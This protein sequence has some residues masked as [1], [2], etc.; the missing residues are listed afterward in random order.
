[1]RSVEASSEQG[2]DVRE[3]PVKVVVVVSIVFTIT[4]VQP[5]YQSSLQKQDR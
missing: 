1:V 5:V 3:N 2:N 4:P